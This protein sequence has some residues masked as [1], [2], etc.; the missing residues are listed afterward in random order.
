MNN[1]RRE[2]LKSAGLLATGLTLSG[3]IELGFDGIK[4]LAQKAKEMYSL[5]FSQEFIKLYEDALRLESVNKLEKHAEI[6]ELTLENDLYRAQMLMLLNQF[7]SR[8]EKI[9]NFLKE[10]DPKNKL[11]E[12]KDLAEKKIETASRIYVDYLLSF[13]VSMNL[14]EI[15]AQAVAKAVELAKTKKRED[16]LSEIYRK[17]YLFEQESVGI[18]HAAIGRHYDQKLERYLNL[19]ESMEYIPKT[20]LEREKMIPDIFGHIVALGLVKN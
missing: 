2:F 8:W 3:F 16:I 20:K 19:Q 4:D 18:W 10:K 1:D 6:G 7:L 17:S 5:E 9:I 14:D 11:S 12:I 13:V 15:K